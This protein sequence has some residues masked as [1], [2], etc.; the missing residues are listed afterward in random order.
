MP[1]CR[2][3]GPDGRP[4]YALYRDGKVCPLRDVMEQPPVES[5]LFDIDLSRLPDPDA[6][7]AERWMDA[8]DVLLPPVPMPEKVFCIGLN[9]R[10]HAI[11]TNSPIPTE[12][13]VFSKFNTALIGH[14]Q[15]IE[16]P[17][18]SEKVDYEAEL[19]VVIGRRAKNISEAEALDHVFGY[20]LR[21]RRLGS[22]LAKGPS[23]RSVAVGQ[24]V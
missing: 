9:Y 8:P 1:I 13:I 23:G 11:E 20:C 16:L 15:A 2:L 7:A 17:P 18:I 14:G 21:T 4:E 19:V 6:I 22:R 12:P 5:E 24:D 10:D 3:T